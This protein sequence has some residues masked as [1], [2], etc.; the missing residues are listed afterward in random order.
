M[1]IL[2]NN[3]IRENPSDSYFTIVQHD[4]GCMLTLPP[5]TIVYG[6]CSGNIPIPLIYEEN[7]F[8]N[9]P[10]KTFHEKQN[11]V[12]LLE[13]KHILSEINYFH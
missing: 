5:N 2:F 12:L 9:Y 1:Q 6:A 3:W 8:V 4:D 10:K 7:T 11:Y 13:I